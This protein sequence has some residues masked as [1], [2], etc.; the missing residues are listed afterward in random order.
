MNV[1]LLR[2]LLL[3]SPLWKSL[4]VDLMQLKTILQVKLKM[5][6]RTPVASFNKQKPKKPTSW[7]SMLQF[8]VMLLL[9]VALLMFFF[10]VHDR[11][12][13]L[14]FYFLAVMCMLSLMLISDFSTILLDTRDQYIILP[15]PVNDR[16]VAI[17]RILHMGIKVLSQLMGIT[18]P[19]FVYIVLFLGVG[20]AGIFLVQTVIIG[21]LALLL[22]N[23]FYLFFLRLLPTQKFKDLISSLQIAFSVLIFGSY[24]LGPKLLQSEYVQ[25][26][27]IEQLAAT[28]FLPPV[29]VASLQQL[30]YTPSVL[31]MVLSAL[32]LCSPLIALWFITRVFAT[33]FSGKM[34]ELGAGDIQPSKVSTAKAASNKTPLHQRLASWFTSSPL[35]SAGFN[36]IWLIT[37]RTREFKQ[38]LYP[39]MAYIP[40]YFFFLFFMGR[41]KD[42][43]LSFSD[44]LRDIEANGSYIVTFYLALFPLLTVLQLVTKSERYKA[45]WVYYVAPLQHPGHLISGVLKA[46]FV[47]FFLPFSLFF[48]LISLPLFGLKI[49]NDVLLSIA[50]GGIEAVLIA[51]FVVKSYPF[52]RPVSKSDSRI[53]V[54]LMVMGVVGLLG[55]GHF[56][57]A[58][59][60]PT[61][62][63]ATIACWGIFLLMLRY[64]KRDKWQGL[65]YEEG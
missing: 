64:F 20:E 42:D 26:V 39:T 57:I 16:T 18:L 47:K 45:A 38:Q 30:L 55:F 53:L 63:I 34:A 41:G 48:L 13:A 60:E 44:K 11:F 31:V 54:N 6:D 36:L 1:L 10:I 12:V 46:C 3:F 7:A 25:E 51:L 37:A 21:L 5:D 17:A 4:G 50:V 58:W 35:E 23:L 8:A 32:A 24:Y 27:H 52:S 43:G 19:A 29:W 59:H 62:W 9:G 14:S 15:R 65:G 28:W 61:V 22:V 2:L 33:G 56:A 49:I 40:V